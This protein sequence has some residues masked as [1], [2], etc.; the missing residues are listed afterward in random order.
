MRVRQLVKYALAAVLSTLWGCTLLVDVSDIDRQC[1][2][3]EKLCS[4][5]CVQRTDPAYGCTAEL[6]SP[7]ALTNAEP[8]CVDG[9]CMVKSCLLGFGCPSGSGC[10]ANIFVDRNH[11]GICDHEC[12][13]GESCRDGECVGS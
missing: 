9:A 8:K 11:C 10:S 2:S 5:H 12:S 7:C 13:P 4:G 3:G 1:A 6:C